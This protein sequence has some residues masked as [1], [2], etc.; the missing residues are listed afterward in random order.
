MFDAGLRASLQKLVLVAA[1][2]GL[3][4]G[5]T[6]GRSRDCHLH[7]VEAV[8]RFVAEIIGL[9]VAGATTAC[10]NG[11]SSKYTSSG[12][13]N[14]VDCHLVTFPKALFMFPAK[15]PGLLDISELLL[16]VVETGHSKIAADALEDP[17]RILTSG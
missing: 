5:D 11:D 6:A 2:G 13:Q 16:E 7:L 17:W 10:R 8:A 4:I 9:A 1:S 15:P 14:T 12:E 3:H